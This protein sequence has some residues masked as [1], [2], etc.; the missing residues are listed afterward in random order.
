MVYAIKLF[1]S[2]VF[3][4]NKIEIIFLQF[5]NIIIIVPSFTKIM[6]LKKKKTM[7]IKVIKNR[8]NHLRYCKINEY[9]Y[10][11]ISL[12]HEKKFFGVLLFAVMT[13]K[14]QLSTEN[15]NIKTER[16]YV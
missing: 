11:Y 16:Y 7:A 6:K 3:E 13:S 12:L 2:D 15:V 4:E 9:I 5:R 14:Y 1:N 8:E 10:I